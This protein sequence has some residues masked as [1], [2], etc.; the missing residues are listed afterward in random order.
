MP[1]EVRRTTSMFWDSHNEPHSPDTATGTIAGN[2]GGAGTRRMV[3]TPSTWGGNTHERFQVRQ[4]AEEAEKGNSRIAEFNKSIWNR[5]WASEKAKNVAR[6]AATT[7][8]TITTSSYA[9]SSERFS[10]LQ[11]AT[12]RGAVLCKGIRYESIFW[13][14]YQRYGN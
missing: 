6:K 4:N 5:V 9:E 2:E 13:H 3:A 8:A 10:Q 7:T 12:Q 11:E 1:E 14:C